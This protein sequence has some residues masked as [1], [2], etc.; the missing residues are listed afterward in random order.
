MKILLLSR[1][2]DY[3]KVYN[4]LSL[5]GKVDYNFERLN[6]NTKEYDLIISCESGP[7]K[8]IIPNPDAV[9]ICYCHSPMRELWTVD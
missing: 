6:P 8:G 4:D 7:T 2:E 3:L 9:H 1:K 5:F